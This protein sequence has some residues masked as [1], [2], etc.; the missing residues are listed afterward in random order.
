MNTATGSVTWGEIE[1]LFNTQ[2]D[3]KDRQHIV[4]QLLSQAYRSRESQDE[5][6]SEAEMTGHYDAAIQRALKGTHR[7]HDRM[8]QERRDAGRL[9]GALEGH[10][11]ARRQVMI[12]NDRRFQTWGLFECLQERY[13]AL[14]DEDPE[15]ALEAAELSW[16]VAQTLDHA[17]Y[18]DE[19]VH[20]FQGSALVALGHARHLQG[21]LEGAK[22]VF[23]QAEAVLALGTGDLLDRAELESLRGALLQAT[24]KPEAANDA[25]RRAG[26]LRQ[27]AGGLRE[28]NPDDD[29]PHEPLHHRLHAAIPGFRPRRR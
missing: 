4:R 28:N 23:E 7:V 11:P 22:A 18:G 16:S 29:H 12:H 14:V 27:R 3:R 8:M 6:R 2:T 15:A 19:R 10:P 26:H 20:D 21:D 17:V 5:A 9:W 24:G 1:K 25:L 13:R